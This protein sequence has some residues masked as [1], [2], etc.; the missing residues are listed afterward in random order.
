MSRP[1]DVFEATR[2]IGTYMSELT[3]SEILRNLAEGEL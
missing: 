2:Q 1:N 3:E